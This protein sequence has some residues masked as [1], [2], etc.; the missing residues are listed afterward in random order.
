LRVTEIERLDW[1]GTERL[2]CQRRKLRKIVA[3][4]G[5]AINLGLTDAEA[6]DLFN[7][8]PDMPDTLLA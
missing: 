7:N 5:E 1:S 8:E 3:R 6:R 2:L 4:I